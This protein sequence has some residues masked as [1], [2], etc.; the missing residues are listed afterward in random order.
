[1]HLGSD[2]LGEQQ[3]HMSKFHK[4][5]QRMSALL[6]KDRFETLLR[7][8]ASSEP[9]EYDDVQKKKESA[10]KSILSH[11]REK[12]GFESLQYG[13]VSVVKVTN[14]DDVTKIRYF[15]RYVAARDELTSELNRWWK[16]LIDSS[17]DIN[18]LELAGLKGVQD[19][20]REGE[21]GAA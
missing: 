9:A 15:M 17:E 16:S 7:R 2:C 13:D 11:I 19:T 10:W 3:Q 6:A 1:M 14:H 12:S 18:W 5:S 20:C 8:T 21:H 4:H